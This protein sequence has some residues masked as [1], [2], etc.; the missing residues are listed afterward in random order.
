MGARRGRCVPLRRHRAARCGGGA[1]ETPRE[2]SPAGRGLPDE[3]S[4]GGGPAAA[5]RARAGDGLDCRRTDGAGRGWIH[6]VPAEDQ[7]I[8][9][10]HVHRE[11]RN[12]LAEL[13][14]QA[15]KDLRGCRETQRSPGGRRRYRRRPRLTRGAEI[16]SAAARRAQMK[17]CVAPVSR[18]TVRRRGPWAAVQRSPDKRGLNS[19][20]PRCRARNS[21]SVA[22]R[23]CQAAANSSMERRQIRG[24]RRRPS[25]QR[26]LGA[27]QRGTR[28][29]PL[30]APRPRRLSWCHH[31]RYPGRG[32]RRRRFRR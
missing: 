13:V 18:R 26:L 16:D 17:Q 14:A 5:A 32:R 24:P 15:Q 8:A 2:R 11:H 30:G 3:R 1:C 12:R 31:P 23:A 28:A 20:V 9:D 27:P 6:P 10:I 4:P 22:K 21:T 19:G 7:V 25:N 29:G